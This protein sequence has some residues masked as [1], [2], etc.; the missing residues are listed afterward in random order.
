MRAT[1]SRS[2]QSRPRL[3]S[4]GARRAR[5]RAGRHE[6]IRGL[7]MD[8]AERIVQTCEEEQRL[9]APSRSA[10]ASSGHDEDPDR[11]RRQQHDCPAAVARE[12][13]GE[14]DDGGGDS[15][16]RSAAMCAASVESLQPADASDQ[17]HKPSTGASS[18]MAGAG[19]LRRQAPRRARARPARRSPGGLVVNALKQLAGTERFSKRGRSGCGMRSLQIVERAGVGPG[20]G[21]GDA[22]GRESTSAREVMA[23]PRQR[24]QFV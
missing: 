5:D 20:S 19:D 15:D 6:Q 14:H 13:P 16:Q 10:P 12:G 11:G 8:V 18:A 24:R 23:R 7:S 4:H 1:P 9:P 17:S 21:A 3:A 22:S 2:P